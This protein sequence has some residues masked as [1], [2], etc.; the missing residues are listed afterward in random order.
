MLRTKLAGGTGHGSGRVD[1][2]SGVRQ[3]ARVVW[4]R[5]LTSLDGVRAMKIGG[6]MVDGRQKRGGDGADIRSQTL[7]EEQTGLLAFGRVVAIDSSGL[8]GKNERPTL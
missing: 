6:V 1:M 2:M 5:G 7:E 4:G 8:E 3:P